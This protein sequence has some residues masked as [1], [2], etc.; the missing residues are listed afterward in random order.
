MTPEQTVRTMIDAMNRLDWEGVYATLAEDVV[1]H[2][3]PLAPLHGLAAVRAF[4][5]AVPP[6]TAC[7][8]QIITLSSDGATVWT[9]RLDDFTMA[10]AHVSLPV[11]GIFEV[12]AGRIRQWRD[13]FDLK[14]F[15]R[16]LGHPLG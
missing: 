10:G 3:M 12:E 4:Y 13:Y 6:I 8:W 11:M 2:N 1:V 15:E 14:D 5:A 7:N 9:E 16:Q